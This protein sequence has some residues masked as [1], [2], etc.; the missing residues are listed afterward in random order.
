MAENDTDSVPCPRCSKLCPLRGD[1]LMYGHGNS[2][3]SS[4]GCL[5]CNALRY[6]PAAAAIEYVL[7]FDPSRGIDDREIFAIRA[8]HNFPPFEP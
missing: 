5:L 2:S 6:I 3:P 1:L 4:G 8:R 7:S